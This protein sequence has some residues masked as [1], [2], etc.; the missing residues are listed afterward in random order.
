[1]YGGFL[2]LLFSADLVYLVKKHLLGFKTCKRIVYEQIHS[3]ADIFLVKTGAEHIFGDKCLVFCLAA[4]AGYQTKHLL[5]HKHLSVSCGH[6]ALGL[7]ALE[8]LQNCQSVLSYGKTAVGNACCGADSVGSESLVRKGECSAWDSA[9]S[10]VLVDISIKNGVDKLLIITGYFQQ[11]SVPPRAV[12]LQGAF[13][14]V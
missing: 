6:T 12:S 7:K 4:V 3:V 10:Y 13:S 1:M 14:V 2:S 8:L 11:R 5:Q 9:L